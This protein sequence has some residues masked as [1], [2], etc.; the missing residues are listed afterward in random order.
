MPEIQGLTPA[1]VWITLA[2][3]VG[4]CLIFIIGYNVY[5]AIHTIVE[6]RKTRREAE[7]PDL[8][9]KISVKVM[10]KIEPR[11][12][13]IEDKLDKDKNRLDNH[14]KLIADVQNS[15][16]DIKNGMVAIC[17]TLVVIMNFG[18]LGDSKEVKEATSALQKYLAGK[19]AN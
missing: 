1:I 16:M 17:Q 5:N 11:L 6:R 3:I 14:E 4:L 12:K 8:A 18:N 7:K 19:I 2:G 9:D 15:Q 10:E 13:E